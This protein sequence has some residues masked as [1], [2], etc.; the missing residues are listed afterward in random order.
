VSGQKEMKHLGADIINDALQMKAEGKTN[1]EISE[2]YE[3]KNKFVIKG[4]VSQ[5]NRK[6]RIM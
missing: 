6:Q 4:L 2:Y 1:R 5:F 3:F